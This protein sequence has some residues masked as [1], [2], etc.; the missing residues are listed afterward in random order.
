MQMAMSVLY[1]MCVYVCTWQNED[2]LMHQYH[3]VRRKTNKGEK[4]SKQLIYSVL[5]FV[6]RRLVCALQR[7]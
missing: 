7:Y 4:H 6:L 1:V 2:V 3:Y 5:F